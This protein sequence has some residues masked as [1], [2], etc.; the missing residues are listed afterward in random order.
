M[1]TKSLDIVCMERFSYFGFILESV[2][3]MGKSYSVF[4]FGKQN[5][6][7]LV[8]SITNFVPE[9]VLGTQIAMCLNSI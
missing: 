1:N 8:R 6:M 9:F 4:M 5:T 2:L 7:L 3:M